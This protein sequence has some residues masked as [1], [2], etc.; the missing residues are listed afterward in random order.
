MGNIEKAKG[1]SKNG[2]RK[3]Q[4]PQKKKMLYK[5]SASALIS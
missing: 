2:E 3:E 1:S 4:S 5:N